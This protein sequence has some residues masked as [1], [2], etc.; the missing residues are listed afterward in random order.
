MENTKEVVKKKTEK[1]K[2][3]SSI[4]LRS[5]IMVAGLL[6]AIL[7]LAG[8]VSNFV[9]QG[10]FSYDEV[11]GAIIPGTYVQGEIKGIA[12]D[13]GSLKT[14]LTNAKTK[15]I[16]GEVILG[17]IIREILTT[18]Q[19]EENKVTKL[20]SKD[21]VE[22][23]VKMPINENEYTL[24]PI[25]SKLPLES[26]HK[27]KDAI[28]SGDKELLKS[29]RKQLRD[30]IKKYANDI[31]TKYIETPYT[32]DFG[33][34]F[35][36][37]EGLYIEALE[38]GLF[39]EVYRDHK[40]YLAGPTTLSAILNALQLSFKS[41]AIQKKSSDVFKL[42]GAVKTEFNKF[43]DTLQKAQRKVDEASNELDSL[44]G[45]RT[46]MIQSKLRTIEYLDDEETKGLLEE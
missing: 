30:A 29:S 39:E 36:P 33:V 17:N 22:F 27:I 32:T 8:I 46:R 2:A 7:I 3:F 24:L 4:N 45:T 40:I 1:E 11:T 14:V 21:P 23:V 41:L 13:V 35:L 5:F 42:L 31:K 26:Y 18:S 10:H 44:V 6:V 25:D 9:P 37:I 20:G 15:G 28:E 16:V 38:M 12:S 43:A 34:M 19:Y